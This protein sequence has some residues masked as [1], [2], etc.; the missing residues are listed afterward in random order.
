[1]KKYILLILLIFATK[2]QCSE[3]VIIGKNAD[4]DQHSQALSIVPSTT[5]GHDDSSKNISKFYELS[6][7]EYDQKIFVESL[8]QHKIFTKRAENFEFLGNIT[9]IA[10]KAL[11]P[12]SAFTHACGND[13]KLNK[14]VMLNYAGH[15]FL[16]AGHIFFADLAKYYMHLANEKIKQIQQIQNKNTEIPQTEVFDEEGEHN[17]S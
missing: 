14:L 3:M 5:M 1:M 10:T 12:V 11:V 13:P 2:V 7:K 8:K 4:D 9:G 15:I 16:C 6:V 17:N